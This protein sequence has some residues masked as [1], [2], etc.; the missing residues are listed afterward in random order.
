MSQSSKQ[1]TKLAK[2]QGGYTLA[3]ILIGVVVAA[4]L[5]AIAAAGY[6]MFNSSNTS[7]NFANQVFQITNNV[8]QSYQKSQTG[9]TNI[10]NDMKSLIQENVFP[11]TLTIDSTAGTVKAFGGAV[12][13]AADSSTGGFTLS[14]ASVPSDTCMKALASMGGSGFNAIDVGGSNLWTTGDSWPAKNTIS[15][16]CGS[17]SG[18]VAMVFH[19]S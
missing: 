8:R 11:D 13:L 3:E 16:Q 14:F 6:R 4:I 9:Y 18:D 15:S 19:A 5:A 12:T 10:A 7:G 2:K 1:L 17:G